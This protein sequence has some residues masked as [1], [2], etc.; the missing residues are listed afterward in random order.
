VH[1]STTA[2]HHDLPRVAQLLPIPRRYEAQGVRRYGFHGLSYA[3][4]MGEL[5]RLQDRN[6]HKAGSS[7]PTSA[8][9]PAW[10]RSAMANPVDTSMV[11]PRQLGVPMSPVRRSRSRM[12]WYLARTE[13]M[14]AKQ[15]N[16]MVNFQSGLLRGFGNQLRY[17]RPA[18]T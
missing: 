14:G 8:M 16:E 15:F 5:A 18:R 7:S 3:L 11:S 4:L 9:E 6:R 1:V 13:K 2:F 17:A 10:R 12:V